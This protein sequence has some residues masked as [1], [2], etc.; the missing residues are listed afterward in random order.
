L[1]S[2]LV[3]ISHASRD[4]WVA[5]PIASRIAEAGAGQFLDAADVH[6]GDDFDVA[7]QEGLQTCTELLALLTPWAVESR[8]VWMEIGAAWGNGKRVTGV[9]QG[10]TIDEFTNRRDV[11]SPRKRRQLIEINDLDTYLDELAE[12]LRAGGR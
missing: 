12:R 11:P 1:P 4:T 3:F 7:I 5:R 2:Q 10:S 9:L 6:T 8:Y